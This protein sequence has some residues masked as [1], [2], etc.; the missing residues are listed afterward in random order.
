MDAGV[1][2]SE[3]VGE[4]AFMAYHDPDERW[5]CLYSVRTYRDDGAARD[6][7]RGGA[8]GEGKEKGGRGKGKGERGEER[9]SGKRA[10][11]GNNYHHVPARSCRSTL[12]V[13]ELMMV[14]VFGWLVGEGF[15]IARAETRELEH[16]IRIRFR[17][18]GRGRVAVVVVAVVDW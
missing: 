1:K 2:G 12:D 3:V 14:L 9:E 16:F 8:G 5:Q 15:P 10:E 18:E 13:R 11:T 6:V 17:G 4:V 7:G